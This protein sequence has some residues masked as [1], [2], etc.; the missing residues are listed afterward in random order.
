MEK[1]KVVADGV[2]LVFFRVAFFLV[3]G[4]A[5]VIFGLVFFFVKE[6]PLPFFWAAIRNS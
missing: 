4:P 3:E 6:L 2:S 1:S 5:F